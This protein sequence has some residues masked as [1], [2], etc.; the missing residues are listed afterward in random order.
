VQI[1]TIRAGSEVLGFIAIDS[2]VAG[3]A[4]GGLRLVPDLGEAE[5]RA[6]ARSMTLKY[7]LL[8]LPQG[9]AKAGILGDPEAPPG[10]RRQRLHAFARTAAPFLKGRRYIPDADIGTTATEVRDMMQS[11]GARVGPREWRGNL[12]GEYTAWS[13]MASAEAMFAHI[14][15]P[16]RGARVAIEGFGKVGSVLARLLQRRGAVIVAVSTSHG[17]VYEPDG[18][19]LDRLPPALMERS[20]LLELPVD[21]LCPCA[22]FESLHA[23]NVERVQAQAIC[24]GANNPVSPD[25]LAVLEARGV[26]CLPDFVS[27]CGGVL[28]GTLE[29]AGMRPEAIGPTIERLSGDLVRSLLARARAEGVSPTVLAERDALARHERVR[30]AAEHPGLVGRLASLG[31]EVYRRGWFPARVMAR[32]APAAIRRRMS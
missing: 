30:H 11:I 12:S 27:N 25:A 15:R 31:L 17:A 24:A 7:G 13:V 2:T 10:E 6:A 16:L 22:R 18:L 19:D 14:G 5:L 8:G 1:H 28:G 3:R 20:R 4:R 26:H 29:F 9:G 21:L 23:G 32:L